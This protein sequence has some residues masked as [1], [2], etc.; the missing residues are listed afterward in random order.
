MPVPE[1]P[2]QFRAHELHLVPVQHVA[3]Y[4]KTKNTQCLADF[5]EVIVGK[6]PDHR[7]R[8][9]AILPAAPELR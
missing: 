7:N 4:G 3:Y 2:V 6:F 9:F 8:L 5:R 1:S